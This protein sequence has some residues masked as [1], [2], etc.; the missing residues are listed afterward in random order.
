MYLWLIT[1]VVW[2]EFVAF[3]Y[4]FI[5]LLYQIRFLF[6]SVYKPSLKHVFRKKNK[7]L[8]LCERVVN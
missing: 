7:Y 1:R 3:R 4:V 2:G 8:K 5:D 6:E